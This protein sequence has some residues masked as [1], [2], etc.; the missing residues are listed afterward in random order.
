LIFAVDFIKITSNP[1]GWGAG[2]PAGFPA[3]KLKIIYSI[4]TQN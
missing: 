3:K 4:T 1:T 2:Q